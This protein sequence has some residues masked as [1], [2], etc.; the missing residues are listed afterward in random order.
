M[1]NGDVARQALCAAGRD[2]GYCSNSYVGRYA[3]DAHLD[4]QMNL[5]DDFCSFLLANLL[6]SIA[7]LDASIAPFPFDIDTHKRS[8]QARVHTS[9]SSKLKLQ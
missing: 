2:L 4:V 9:A 8:K 3:Q 6:I 7:F 5:A 1:V